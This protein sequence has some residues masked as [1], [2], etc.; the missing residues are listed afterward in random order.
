MEITEDSQTRNKL[1]E[2]TKYFKLALTDK[3]KFHIQQ[4]WL[5]LPTSEDTNYWE[6]GFK[7]T[8][9]PT[10][11]EALLRTAPRV[12]NLLFT[13]KLSELQ[14]SVKEVESFIRNKVNSDDLVAIFMLKRLP[15]KAF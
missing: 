14:V 3:R 11:R 15:M 10:I 4:I 13:S 7:K 5:R 2:T 9:R 12:L 8:S 6:G 1:N